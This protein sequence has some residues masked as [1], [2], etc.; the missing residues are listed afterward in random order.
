MENNKMLDSISKLVDAARETGAHV[1][2]APMIVNSEINIDRD[3]FYYRDDSL[4]KENTW[5]A[6]IIDRFKPKDGDC[7][8]KNKSGNDCFRGSNLKQLISEK[9]I[10]TLIVGGFTT[11]G[12]VEATLF[13]ADDLGVKTISL[14]DGTAC[15]S[16]KA[17][18]SATLGLISTLMSCQEVT[19]VLYKKDLN[20]SSTAS[21]NTRI[22]DDEANQE[23]ENLGD[24]I[25]HIMNGAVENDSFIVKEARQDIYKLYNTSQVFIS[26]EGDWTKGVNNAVRERSQQRTCWVRG[27]YTSPYF[28]ATQFR[29][30]V[31]IASGIGITP[32]LGVMGQ[33][34]GF[35]RTKVL[36]WM[37]RSKVMLKFFI[38]LMEDSHLALIFYTGK[39]KLTREEVDNLHS[40]GNIRV[41]QTRPESLGD[42]IESVIVRFENT[43]EDKTQTNSTWNFHHTH[44]DTI[45]LRHKESWCVMYCGGSVTVKN[46]LKGFTKENSLGFKAEFFDW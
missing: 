37:V 31:L 24:F 2:H 27:P 26:P 15:E 34:P 18:N 38:P 29:H 19:E 14:T 41:Q 7:V 25:D 22:T 12:S 9:G 4:F 44:L 17:Q 13:S 20:V 40:Q 45:Q 1:F 10:E 36:I 11:D 21:M 16:E 5:N 30:L 39:E 8:V 32:A 43:F 23:Y 33:Y 35:S 46:L 3:V 28:I 42:T 6:E